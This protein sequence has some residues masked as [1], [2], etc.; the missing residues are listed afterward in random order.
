M[1][2]IFLENIGAKILNPYW[3]DEIIQIMLYGILLICYIVPV[4]WLLTITKY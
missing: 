1:N 3:L 2:F 4:F